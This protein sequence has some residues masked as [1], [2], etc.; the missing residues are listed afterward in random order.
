MEDYNI[1]SFCDM[2]FGKNSE[3][4][5][6]EEFSSL[7][8]NIAHS[9][10][11]KYVDYCY[12]LSLIPKIKNECIKK[13][14]YFAYE[15][16]WDEE[17]NCLNYIKLIPVISLK[18]NNKDEAFCELKNL[19]KSYKVNYIQEEWEFPK[20]KEKKRNFYKIRNAALKKIKEEMENNKNEEKI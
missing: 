13:K 8:A 5:Q 3:E 14:C 10:K 18:K 11:E 15:I 4:Q 1:N 16:Y 2:I 19:P 7:E 20:K 17:L 12:K 6:F 9:I